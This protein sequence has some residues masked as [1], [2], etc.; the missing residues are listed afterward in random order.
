GLA[1]SVP[2]G[3]LEEC[4]IKVRERLEALVIEAINGNVKSTGA[5]LKEI[6]QAGNRL[7]RAVFHDPDGPG[8]ATKIKNRLRDLP[9][10]HQIY[11]SMGVPL[12]VPWGLVYDGDPNQLSG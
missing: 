8:K 3:M 12:H 1:Y 5:I 2:R 11:F 10:E 4:S 7:Y 9:A 6:A